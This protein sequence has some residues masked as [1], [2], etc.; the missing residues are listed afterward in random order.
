MLFHSNEP[1]N[2]TD[3]ESPFVIAGLFPCLLSKIQQTKMLVTC[4]RFGD[5]FL[6]EMVWQYSANQNSEPI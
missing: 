1:H 2:Q 6:F 5:I 3:T 4:Q